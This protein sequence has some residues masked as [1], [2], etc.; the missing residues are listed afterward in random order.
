MVIFREALIKAF[1]CT[2]IVARSA[3]IYD[4]LCILPEGIKDTLNLSVYP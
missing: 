3:F 1:P 4:F 2:K